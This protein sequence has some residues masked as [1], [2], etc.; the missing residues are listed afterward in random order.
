M[1]DKKDRYEIT[2]FFMT[3]AVR[4]RRFYG[5]IKRGFDSDGI[6]VVYG[7]ITVNNGFVCAM[8]ACQDVLGE[9]LD[10]IVKMVLGM[11]M[12]LDAGATSEVAGTNYYL[13]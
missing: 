8:A 11:G 6:P 9:R 3:Q 2:E 13:N 4:D 1:A 7:K 10:E 12:H 5:S